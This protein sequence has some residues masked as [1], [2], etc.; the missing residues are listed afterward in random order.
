MA[1][2]AGTGLAI[3]GNQ[4]INIT[5]GILD[6]F[7]DYVFNVTSYHENDGNMLTINGDG[8]HSV[9]FDFAAGLNLGGDVTLVGLTPDQV[10]W[11]FSGSTGNVQLNNNASSFPNVA[12]QGILLAPN[13]AISLVNANFTGRIFGGDSSD[14]QIVSGV[15]ALAPTVPAPVPEPASVLLLGSGLTLAARRIRRSKR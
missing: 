6:A 2:E 15:H 12:F 9:V 10:L 11:N 3:N 4:A 13:H 8:I 5:N 7:G 14:M 1:G